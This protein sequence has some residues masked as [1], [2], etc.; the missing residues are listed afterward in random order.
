[1]KKLLLITVLFFLVFTLSACEDMCIGSECILSDNGNENPDPNP[2]QDIECDV[3]E[4][5]PEVEEIDGTVVQNA[6]QYGHIN[7]HGVVTD[8]N[9]FVLLEFKL[10]DYIR[11]QV[12]YLSCTCRPADLNYWQVAFVE[13]SLKTSSVPSEIITL[14]FNDDSGGHYTAGMWGDSITR[15]DIDYGR[16]REDFETEFIPWIVGKSL[17]DFDGISV[18]T[19]DDYFGIQNTTVIAET[20]LIDGFAGSSV[21][22]NNMIRVM[23]SLLEYHVEKYD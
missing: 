15:T 11:Y 21:S 12:T 14:S 20:E 17:A 7:G 9:A 1:M 22:T 3:C 8:K 13:I 10:R 5:C 6:I 18:F 16:T 23:K 2:D 19:N 4:D